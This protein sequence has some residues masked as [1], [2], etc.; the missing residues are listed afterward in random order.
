MAPEINDG[1][2]SDERGDI[3][4]VGTILYWLATGRLPFEAANP[5]ALFKRILDGEFEDPQ[6]L[7]PKIGTSLSRTIK[8][9]TK[10]R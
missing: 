7:E 2:R 5:S 3:F 1:E 6:M 9:A 4:S 8:K 10:P